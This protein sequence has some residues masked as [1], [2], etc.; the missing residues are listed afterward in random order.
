MSLFLFYKNSFAIILGDI[1]WSQL[2]LEEKKKSIHF[3]FVF[4]IFFFNRRGER[5]CAN[6]ANC[7]YILAYVRVEIEEKNRISTYILVIRMGGNEKRTI[8]LLMRDALLPHSKEEVRSV[9]SELN[10]RI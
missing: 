9:D 5:S 8:S 1:S 7:P 6:S 10:L 3:F 4:V 2:D